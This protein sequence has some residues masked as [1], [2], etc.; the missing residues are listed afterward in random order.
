MSCLAPRGHDLQELW[1]I[2]LSSIAAVLNS[3]LH[4]A[5]IEGLTFPS[6]FFLL[7]SFS[8]PLL[9]AKAKPKK[10]QSKKPSVSQRRSFSKTAR[11]PPRKKKKVVCRK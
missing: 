4:L 10:G 5:H 6:F 3:V 1:V 7:A 11:V 8:E 9:K 2:R